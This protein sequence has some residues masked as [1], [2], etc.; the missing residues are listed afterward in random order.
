M[1][2]L[3]KNTEFHYPILSL[4]VYVWIFKNKNLK[5]RE[6]KQRLREATFLSVKLEEGDKKWSAKWVLAEE[7]VE[8]GEISF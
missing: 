6:E 4:F 5:R 3:S 8:S 2:N 7:E 1:L